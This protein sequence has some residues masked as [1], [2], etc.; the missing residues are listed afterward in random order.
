MGNT[1]SNV[2]VGKP[3]I[4]GGIFRAPLGSTLPTNPTDALDAA[5]ECVGYI[6]SDGVANSQSRENSEVVAWGGDVVLTPQTKK[7]DTFKWKMIEVENL[8]VLKTAYGNDNVVGTSLTDG[9]TIKAN[10]KE[11]DRAAWVIDRILNDGTKSRTVIPDGQPTT[12]EDIV[13]KDEEAIGFDVTINAKPY[14]PFEGDTH[15]EYLKK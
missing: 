4:T 11:L 10:A 14:S 1:A 12:L 8:E 9:I 13:Y 3:A 7:T 2:S 15:R 5:F 6:S